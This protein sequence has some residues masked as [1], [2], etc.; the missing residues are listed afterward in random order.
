MGTIVAGASGGTGRAIAR[1]LADGVDDAF[2]MTYHRRA[3]RADDVAAALREAGATAATVSL[4]ATEP[5]SVRDRLA[6]ADGAVE[7]VDAVVSTTGIVDPAPIE[8]W[9]GRVIETNRTGSS[10]AAEAAAPRPRATGGSL[11][12][13]SR[14]GG[15]AGTVDTSH[16]ASK[17]G[18]HG[19]VRA[20]ARELG[21]DGVRVN[22][23]APG[24]VERSTNDATPERPEAIDDRGHEDLGTHTHLAASACPPAEVAESVASPLASEFTRGQVLEVNGGIHQ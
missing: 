22:A 5:A 15:T 19:L 9:W 21:P 4:D 24:P 6:T 11:V 8:S 16:A 14:V 23:V 13:L 10:R 2:V 18:L 17:A 7:S 12:F 20:L 3:A 1:R